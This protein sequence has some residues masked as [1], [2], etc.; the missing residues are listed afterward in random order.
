MNAHGRYIYPCRVLP[1]ANF[2]CREVRLRLPTHGN[3]I[4]HAWAFCIVRLDDLGNAKAS[5]VGW[6]KANP[7]LCFYKN[8]KTFRVKIAGYWGSIRIWMRA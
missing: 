7:T 1:Y 6:A 2:A 8:I 3:D 4:C 5:K